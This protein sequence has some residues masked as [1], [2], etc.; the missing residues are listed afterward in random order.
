MRILSR[1]LLALL[2]VA[3]ACD[4]SKPKKTED[5][6]AKKAADEEAEKEKRI[7]QRRKDREAKAAAEKQAAEDQKKA[8]DALCV[9]PEGVKKPKKLDQACAAAGDAQI[10]FLK[11]AFADK[12]EK[13]AGV[14]KNAAMQKAQLLKSCGS[15]DV[16][17]GLKNAFDNAPKEYGPAI[18]DIIGTCVGKLGP[19]A[20][21]AGAGAVP[22]KR[23]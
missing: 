7:E 11:R 1:S 18:S 21:P 22:P 2:F 6:A 10:E 15:I 19:A 12:P 16:A 8:I 5:A 9:V 13:L 17:L 14:E 3:P 4:S 23:K 20:P